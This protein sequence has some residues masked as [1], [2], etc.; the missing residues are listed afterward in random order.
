MSDK[1]REPFNRRAFVS[2]LTAFSFVLMALT[3][4]VLFFAPACRIA[5]DTSWTVWGHSKEQ[6]VAVHAW[7]C[8]TFVIASI[9]HIYLNW[10][11]LSNYFKTKLRQGLA[12]RAEWILALVIC[13]IIYA[14]TVWQAAPFSSLIAWKDTFKHPVAGAGQYGQGWRGGRAGDHQIGSQ[15]C[16]IEGYPAGGEQA[17]N[18]RGGY[19]Q[20]SHSGQEQQQ[21][22]PCEQGQTQTPGP[23]P[24]R[25]GMG[26]KTL[27]QFCSD[28][29]IELSWALS[30]LRNE[31]FTARETMTMREI[32]DGA[33]VHPRQ[34][35]AVLQ[36]R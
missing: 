25:G 23:G 6:W 10:S 20:Q 27:R 34:L 22:G 26:Q 2:V 21:V 30:R 28:E 9:F 16:P 35:R 12:F 5:R 29:G 32:A 1:T 3:G 36:A 14:G 18:G 8:I 7:F 31:G 11:A 24:I 33:G 17:L 4:L 15:L 19:Y 13:V